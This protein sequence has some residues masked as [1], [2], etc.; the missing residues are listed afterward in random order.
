MEDLHDLIE[1]IVMMQKKTC[2]V[3]VTC[4]CGQIHRVPLDGYRICEVCGRKVY[5]PVITGELN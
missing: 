4:E 3:D 2:V 5:S 1:D